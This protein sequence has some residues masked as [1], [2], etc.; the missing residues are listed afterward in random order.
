MAKYVLIHGAGHGG[1]CW[2]R[3][4]PLLERA[5]HEVIAPT[6]KGVGE[7]K[8]EATPELDLDTHIRE[9]VTLIANHEL[10]DVILVGHS[11]GG[12]V[13]TGVADRVGTRICR[14]VY[15]DAAIPEDGEALI[16]TSPGLRA[17]AGQDLRTVEGVELAMW[18]AALMSTVYGLIEPDDVAFAK[19]RLT[20]HPWKT[21]IQPLC[22][23]DVVALSGIPRAIVNCSST[24]AR[25]PLET[26]HRWS[27]GDP[28]WEIDS[29]HDLMITK[30]RQVA[31][32]LLQLADM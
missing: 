11:Y 16:D 19:G 21:M 18:P 5:G 28:V 8:S 6:L 31:D 25:R 27:A 30:P 1:W 3:V 24:L 14:L 26:R 29:G 10:R 13:I 15:L 20:P 9:V 2:D 4:V 22:L 7:R 17:L 32:M 23:S 12:M